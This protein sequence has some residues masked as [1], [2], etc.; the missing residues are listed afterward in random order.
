MGGLR[1]GG[2]GCE[3]LY[4]GVIFSR[5]RL[6][7]PSRVRLVLCEPLRGPLNLR[8]RLVGL[9]RIAGGGKPGAHFRP[10]D[11]ARTRDQGL[12]IETSLCMEPIANRVLGRDKSIASD[13]PIRR[14]PGVDRPVS[15]DGTRLPPGQGDV[16]WV[17]S[18]RGSA[19]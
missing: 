9:S 2:R 3:T 13:L 14:F 17:L 15:S 10:I 19:D 16:W 4:A 1:Q 6:W 7:L 11:D 8:P 18:R 5:L 12:A